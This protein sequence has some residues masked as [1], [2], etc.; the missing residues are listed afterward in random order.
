MNT[1]P[2]EDR[3]RTYRNQE[4]WQS[5]RNDKRNDGRND[6]R[7]DDSFEGELPPEIRTE[8]FSGKIPL[9]RSRRQPTR[10]PGNRSRT[11]VGRVRPPPPPDVPGP[12]GAPPPNTEAP[13]RGTA[14][15]WAAVI[16]GISLIAGILLAINQLPKQVIFSPPI[17]PAPSSPVVEVRRALPVVEVRRA[18]PAVPRALLVSSQA[19]TVSNTNWQAIR[20]PDGTIVQVSYQGELPRSAARP[21]RGRFLGEEYSTGNTSWIWMTPVGASFPS[22]V[23]P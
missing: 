3:T 13:R 9:Y 15:W 10:M 16:A 11:A 19:S 4:C 17:D 23:D 12:V 1:F 6:N 22:W 2:S 7:F 20:M 21:P 8:L 14:R 18:L 5:C